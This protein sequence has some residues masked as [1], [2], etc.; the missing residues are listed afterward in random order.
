MNIFTPLAYDE[1]VA[2]YVH[3][4]LLSV[5]AALANARPVPSPT[6]PYAAHE[7]IA[8][9]GVYDT[10]NDVPLMSEMIM[11]PLVPDSVTVPSEE[12]AFTVMVFVADFPP[13]VAV[14]TAVPAATPVTVPVD[15]LTVARLV[16]PLDHDTVLFVALPGLTVAL[17]V[18]VLPAVTELLPLIETLVT[19][20]VELPESV[21]LSSID[22]VQPVNT[23]ADINAANSRDSTGITFIFIFFKRQPHVIS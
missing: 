21:L 7:V 9:D 16:L 1:S 20:T 11:L 2:V 19:A 3:V 12:A 6:E 17:R 13:A 23:A 4:P 5:I 15:E 22:V 8:A 14:M 10:V 18:I